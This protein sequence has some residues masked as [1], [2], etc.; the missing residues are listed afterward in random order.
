MNRDRD[1]MHCIV[2]REGPHIA[3]LQH[4]PVLGLNEMHSTSHE[5]VSSRHAHRGPGVTRLGTMLILRF[6]ITYSEP[7]LTLWQ[8]MLSLKFPA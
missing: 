7:R 3:S 8:T 5:G 1:M 4:S 2:T 6:D